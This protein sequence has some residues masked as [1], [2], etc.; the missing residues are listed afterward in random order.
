[1]SIH[2]GETFMQIKRRISPSIDI[3]ASEQALLPPPREQIFPS[4]C[5]ILFRCRRQRDGRINKFK[6][7]GKSHEKVFDNVQASG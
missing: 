3:C 2:H 4:F 6:K 1:M 7:I 5:K